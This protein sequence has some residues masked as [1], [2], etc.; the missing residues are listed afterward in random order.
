MPDPTGQWWQ[1]QFTNP[2]T[3]DHITLVQP[4]RGDRSRW[5]SDVTLTFDGKNPVRYDLA[6]ASHV[7][8]GQTLT[9]PSR[10]FHTLRVTI[11]GT[12]NNT[13]PPSSASAVGFAEI[14][15][16]G[17]LVHQVVPM[18]TQML[19]TLGR[20]L[21]RRPAHR[22][23]DTSAHLAVPAA[24][25]PRDDHHAPV[26]APDRPHVRAVR[27]SASLSALVPDDEI[28]RLVG[29]APTAAT[30]VRDAYSS[31]RLPGCR[32]GHRLGHR[33]RDTTTAWQPGLGTNAQ[34][35]STV[36]Y[37]LTKPQTL[38]GLNMQVIAD[39]RHSVPT[40]HDDHLGRARCG[41]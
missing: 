7:T 19:S 24:E 32:R 1:A 40:A 4:Q 11:D 25:R 10:T 27:V 15:I 28:D 29:R 3:T 20:V 17:Q 13:A 35:G 2:V 22:G 41:R 21:C 8:T 39:G 9:F 34:V 36:T 26:H 37:D 5:V 6:A 18:P 33:R 38:S 31:G 14:E 12:T 16:P 23:D 30:G